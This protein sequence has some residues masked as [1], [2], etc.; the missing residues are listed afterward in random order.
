MGITKIFAPFLLAGAA[1]GAIALAPTAAAGSSTEC[2][3]DG[4]AAVCT[5]N[6]HASISATPRQTGQQ[7]FSI[8]P[9][10]SP[11]GSGPMPPLLAI[12]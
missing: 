10:G 12:D 1:A 2:D 4:P 9:G 5:R 7:F 8:A 11:F 3:N 6:G